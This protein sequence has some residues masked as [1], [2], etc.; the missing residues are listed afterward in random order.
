MRVQQNVSTKALQS[1]RDVWSK[2]YPNDMDNSNYGLKSKF[3]QQI[4]KFVLVC[5]VLISRSGLNLPGN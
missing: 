2:E 5:E 3:R 1:R 4:A